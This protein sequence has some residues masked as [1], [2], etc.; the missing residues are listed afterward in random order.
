MQRNAS[1]TAIILHFDEIP[2]PKDTRGEVSM[3]S[4]ETNFKQ[5]Q[6]TQLTLMGLVDKSFFFLCLFE[7]YQNNQSIKKRTTKDPPYPMSL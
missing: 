2:S 5:Y 3:L 1:A 4:L 7:R 6:R